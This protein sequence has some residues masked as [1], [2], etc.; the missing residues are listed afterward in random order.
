MAGRIQ[1]SAYAWAAAGPALATLAGLLTRSWLDLVNVALVYVVAVVVVSLRAEWKA[2]VA[3]S[4]LSV[5][6]FDYLFVPPYGTFTVDDPQH[7]LTFALLGAVGLVVARLARLGR[8][9]AEEQARLAVEAE[10]ERIRGTLLA[11]ISH[12]LR[13]PLAV[14]CGAASSLAEQGESLAPA[15]RQALVRSIYGES[16]EMSERIAKILQMTR[17]EGGEIELHRD[18][19]SIPEIAASVLRQQTPRLARHRVLFDVP[20]DLPLVRVDAM[21]VETVL[22]NLVE[23]AA[24]HTPPETVVRLVG[25]AEG[26]HLLIS[27]E[28]HG[29][30][31]D[32]DELEGVFGK[33]QRGAGGRTPGIGLGLAICRAV[34][35]LHG[36]RI[37]AETVAGGGTAFRF[38]LPT[39]RAPHAP[40][41]AQVP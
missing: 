23:N 5:A 25:K 35:T 19:A 2:A 32:K 17:L 41:E 20:P 39:E 22:A 34:V 37:W 13:T 28:S 31:L 12:D 21:L 38:T 15:E 1:W 29:G 27:V 16:V 36:G 8:R 11:S 24:R 18:W 26:D 14:I 7:L 3:A 30:G 40:L 6:T 33:F 10:T 9:Q 4:L